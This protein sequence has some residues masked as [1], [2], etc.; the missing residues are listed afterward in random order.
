LA[1]VSRMTGVGS[2]VGMVYLAKL[3]Q[4]DQVTNRNDTRYRNRFPFPQLSRRRR[5]RV[6]TSPMQNEATSGRKQPRSTI[7]LRHCSGR[8]VGDDA[9]GNTSLKA[10]VFWAANKRWLEHSMGRGGRCCQCPCAKK[11]CHVKWQAQAGASASERRQWASLS[12]W[13]H[14]HVR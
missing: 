4:V 11:A 7:P 12:R 10:E 14:R 5:Q 1:K 2:G 8:C 9:G 3:G 6:D 13:S